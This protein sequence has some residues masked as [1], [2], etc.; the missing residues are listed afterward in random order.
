MIYSLLVPHR[1]AACVVVGLTV[2][3]ARIREQR[4]R[5]IIRRQIGQQKYYVS[6]W[7]IRS[8]Y[9]KARRRIRI[10]LS[11]RIRSRQFRIT[12]QMAFRQTFDVVADSVIITALP[13]CLNRRRKEAKSS[14]RRQ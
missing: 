4:V 2:D 9:R 10:R 12:G 8:I 3:A 11:A 7:S 13:V 14:R 1:L 6:K 5:C